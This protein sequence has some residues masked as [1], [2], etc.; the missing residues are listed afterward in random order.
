MLS[1]R[2]DELILAVRELSVTKIADVT[3]GN[4]S[5][6]VVNRRMFREERERKLTRSR[7]Q[8][9]RNGKVKRK[10]NA[11]VTPPS[12]S[13]SS[14]ISPPNGGDSPVQP[15]NTPAK[16]ETP[17]CPHDEIRALYHDKL[18][19]LPPVLSWHEERQKFLRAR[20][21]EKPE[22]QNLQWWSEFFDRVSRSDFLMGRTPSQNGKK[23][24]KADLE[25]LVRPRNFAKIIEG[26]YDHSIFVGPSSRKGLTMEDIRRMREE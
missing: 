4:D 12:S 22:R 18:P 15:D 24:F 9:H 5:V 16:T 8:K 7:V 2:V 1:C 10:S 14:Y 19:E 26:K 20:W 21:R 25:W 6:T 13:S 23:P 17:N 11:S 3:E